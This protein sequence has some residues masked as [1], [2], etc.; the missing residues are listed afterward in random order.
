MAKKSVTFDVSMITKVLV[1]LL[2][3]FIGISGFISTRGTD[4]TR[5][6]FRFLSEDAFIYIVSA[7]VAIAGLGLLAA[8]FISGMPAQVGSVSGI[9]AIAFWVMVIVFKDITTLGDVEMVDFVQSIAVD[10][11]ILIAILESTVGSKK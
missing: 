2:L 11:I 7:I 6:L 3:I 1:A 8:N 10:A 9:I 5:G 4:F